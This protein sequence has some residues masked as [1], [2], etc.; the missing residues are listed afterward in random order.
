DQAPDWIWD[1][2]GRITDTGYTVEIRL[3]LQSIRFTGG[4]NVRMGI[5][6]WRRVRRFGVSVAWPPI[7]PGTW[8]FEKHASLIVPELHSRP[9]REVIPTTTCATNQERST[10]SQ[11]AAAHNTGN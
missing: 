10:P 11:W 5:L 4:E 7:D 6:F 2:A 8:V 9:P 3:P 1:S